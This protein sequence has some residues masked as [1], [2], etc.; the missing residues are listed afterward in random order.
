VTVN[1]DRLNRVMDLIH[2][3]DTGDELD[4]FPELAQIDSPRWDQQEWGKHSECGTACCFAG[5]TLMLADP[6]RTVWDTDGGDMV[7]FTGPDGLRTSVSD[8]AAELLGLDWTTADHLFAAYNSL[9][10]LQEI[11]GQIED[12]NRWDLG[13]KH[14]VHVEEAP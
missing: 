5:W 10:M 6:S 13:Y 14:W 8:A 9:D 12:G 3:L 1:I 2:R 7:G 4:G 11:V